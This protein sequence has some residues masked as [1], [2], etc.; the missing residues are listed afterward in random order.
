MSA[1]VLP[2]LPDLSV[3]SANIRD[4]QTHHVTGRVAAISGAT[5]VV[6]GM[7]APVGAVCEIRTATMIAIARVVGFTV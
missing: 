1:L 3:M 4:A 5:V 2:P 6:E 7:S